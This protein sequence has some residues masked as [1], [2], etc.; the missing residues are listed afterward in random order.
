M[1]LRALKQVTYANVTR[2]PGDHF[3]ASD[4]DAKILIGFGQ[5][6]AVAPPPPAAPEKSAAPE[7]P[8]PAKTLFEQPADEPPRKRTYKR[9]DLTAE[10]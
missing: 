9:R 10:Q 7:P 2:G 6:V 5:A 8:D 3:D 1:R 4:E